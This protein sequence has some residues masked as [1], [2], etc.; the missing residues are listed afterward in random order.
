KVT[1]KLEGALADSNKEFEYEVIFNG[2]SVNAGNYDVF[3]TNN[4]S[5]TA[6]NLDQDGQGSYTFKLKGNQSITF[7]NLTGGVEYT[8]KQLKYNGYSTSPVLRGEYATITG[9]TNEEG[10]REYEFT[11]TYSAIGSVS[12]N[13]KLT[14][15]KELTNDMFKI[16]VDGVEYDVDSNGNIGSINKQYDNE[17]GQFTYI[18]KQVNTGL[19][20]ISY[21]SSE[22]KAVVNVT[23]D[24]EGN[25]NTQLKYYDNNNNE[26]SEVVFNNIYLPNGLTISNVNNSEYVDKDKIFTY[27]ITLTNG[28]G[29]YEVKDSKGNSLT[30]IEFVD[31]TA[32]YSVNLLSNESIL[33]SDL[34]DGVDYIIKQTLVEYYETTSNEESTISDNTIVVTG[35]TVEGS[36]EIKFDNRYETSA[37][38]EPNINVQLEGKEIEA[39]EF[40]FKLLDVSEGATNGYTVNGN[41]NVEGL[42]SFGEINY[43]RP[44]T[45]RYEIVQLD[46]GSNH[47][48]FDFSKV[49]LVLELTDNGDGTME[50]L[51]SYEYENGQEF[52][53]N[54]YSEE[55]IVKEDEQEQGKENPKT[56]DRIRNIIILMLVAISLFA[57]E[58]WIR[59]RRYTMNA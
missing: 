48:Y 39:N 36:K 47:I 41:N 19:N 21:D 17:V 2:S 24:K 13:A 3:D 52:L 44:G 22:Y 6:L 10:T 20:K 1:N 34:P 51:S 35:T 25:L 50:V 4:E 59:Y 55:P 28:E 38:F 9:N 11:N 32:T 8:I 46:N 57:V 49:Y 27:E 43:T 29:T 37:S 14:Y 5:L 31:G 33:I 56:A 12:L 30:N 16:S 45:Y 15:D 54:K 42:V 40:T 26:V 7:K 53:A 23:D 58:R 18:I